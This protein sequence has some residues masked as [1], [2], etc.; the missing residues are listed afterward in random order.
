[1]RAEEYLISGVLDLH[2]FLL[3]LIHLLRYRFESLDVKLDGGEILF[4]LIHALHL[5]LPHE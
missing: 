2:D 3:Q 5:T 1:M 4:H